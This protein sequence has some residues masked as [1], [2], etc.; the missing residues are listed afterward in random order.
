MSARRV[1]IGVDIGGT[2]TDLVLADNRGAIHNIK[3][4]TTT[5]DP[6]RGVMTAVRQGLDEA[7]AAAAEV[8]RFVHATTLPTNLV[9]ERKGAK[10]GLIATAGFGDLFHIGKQHA[11]GPDRFNLSYTPP[12]ALLPRSMVAEVGER[13]NAAGSVLRP[14]DRADAERAV[15]LLVDRGAEAIAVCLLNSYANP[16]HEAII[17]EVARAAAPAAYICLSS[18][19]W[20]EFQEYERAATTLIS[21]YIG[22]TLANYVGRL[23]DALRGIGID[24]ELQIM[25]SSGAVMGAAMAAR[26]AAYAI[27]SGPAAGVMAAAHLARE[28]GRPGLVSFDMGGTTAKAGL[29][30]D[31]EPRITHQFRAGG[32]TSAAGRADAGEPIKVPVID[33]AEVGAGGGSIARVD[34]GGF[35]RVGPQSASS[36]PG[37]ACY[38]LGGTLPTV[39]DANVVLGYI[40]PGYFAGGSITLDAEASRRAIE[41]HVAR[42]L[43]LDVVAAARGIHALANTAMAAAIRV[44]TLQRG[45]DPRDHALVASG[46]AGPIHA[47]KLAELFGIETVIIPPSPGVRSAWGLL[48]ADLAHDFVATA[49]MPATAA[50]P[51]RIAGLF[52]GLEEK[53]RQALAH[54]ASAETRIIVQRSIDVRLAHQHQEIT[55]PLGDGAIDGELLARAEADFRTVYARTF[56]VRPKEACQ[57]VNF[58]L[59]ISA[60]VEKPAPVVRAWGDGS[61]DRARKGV[62]PAWFDGRSLATPVFDRVLLEPGDRIMGPAIIEE[63]DSSTICPDGYLAS[64]DLHDNLL[65]S[66]VSADES[67]GPEARDEAPVDRTLHDALC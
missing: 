46:G 65:I 8:S 63:P 37:P 39:T 29:V 10:L 48:I 5:D 6:V 3:T 15:R 27:E 2:F 60:V 23:E 56:G 11:I 32:G 28:A 25:Q 4:L 47:V 16:E 30:V 17:G 21:A 61:A 50:D 13:V 42:P 34:T 66:P 57:F 41:E 12:P 36:Y 62:R 18:E 59:R 52:A 19:V 24:A 22:P 35:L 58:R 40:N 33:L 45:I 31:G 53:G 64:V 7:G 43:G 54:A 51:A 49:I 44:V 9:L 67:A 26:K 38:G 20:P 1:F 55:V 14:I